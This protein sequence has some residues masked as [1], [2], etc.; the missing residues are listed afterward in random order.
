MSVHVHQVENRRLGRTLM[1]PSMSFL[2]GVKATD[3]R[4]S[5]NAHEY[6]VPVKKDA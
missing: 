5:T 4:R 6:G 1:F 3:P 2:T